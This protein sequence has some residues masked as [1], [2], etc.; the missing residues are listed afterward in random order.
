MASSISISISTTMSDVITLFCWIR[1]TKTDQHFGVTISR[2]ETVDAL[3]NLLKESQAIE[4]PASALR[5]Y[6]PIDPVA[7]PYDENLRNI[8]L[9]DLRKPLIATRKLSALFPAV[10]PEEHIHVIVG[11]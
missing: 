1:G 4:V 2:F 9:S 11:M 6:K 5:L 8:A 10:L 3:K 7:E